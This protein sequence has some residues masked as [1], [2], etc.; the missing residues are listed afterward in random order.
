MK[1]SPVLDGAAA[2]LRNHVSAN[3]KL[4]PERGEI[5]GDN[6]GERCVLNLSSPCVCVCVCMCSVSAR[7]FVVGNVATLFIR[8]PRE[9]GG[10]E[11]ARVLRLAARETRRLSSCHVDLVVSFD[12]VAAFRGWFH[13]TSA[14]SF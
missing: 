10:T 2:F 9:G 11:T 3:P 7:V 5:E 4:I 12:C 1:I 6:V 14:S 13:T 8:E